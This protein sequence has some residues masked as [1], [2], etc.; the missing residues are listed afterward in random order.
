VAQVHARLGRFERIFY[1]A[2]VAQLAAMPKFRAAA[3]KNADPYAY[4][5][6]FIAED[7]AS[8]AS[9][10]VPDEDTTAW[11]SDEGALSTFILAGAARYRMPTLTGWKFS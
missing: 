6:L 4:S 2:C 5:K 1:D 10:F 9:E 3:D 8:A 11:T 7:A